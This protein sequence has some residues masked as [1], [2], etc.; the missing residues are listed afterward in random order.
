MELF[1]TLFSAVAW[2][3]VYAEAIRV[4]LRDRTYAMPVAA[5]ALNFAWEATYA[6]TDFLAGVSPQGVVNVVWAAADV[7]IIGT[8]LRFGRAELPEFVTRPLFAGWS[9]LVFAGAFAVQWLFLAQ[10]GTHDASRY[11]AFLQ[12]L[13]MSGLFIALYAGRRGPRG[14][15]LVIAVAKWLGTL[16]PTLLFGV[17]EDAPFILGLG[18]LCSVFDL[19]YI[20]LLA[21]E[22]RAGRRETTVRIPAAP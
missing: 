14:Q 10:F 19:A 22:G 18:V 13:L 1:L 4:G 2:T 11:S 7:V 16:A 21:R 9:A 6:T 15:S 8:Y 5:L 20:A 12:N 3:L 17:I